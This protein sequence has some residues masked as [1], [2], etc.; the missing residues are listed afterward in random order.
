[1]KMI[2][3][4]ALF[5]SLGTAPDFTLKSLD[6]HDVRL[7]ALRGNV[8]IVSFW[9]TWCGGCKV[10]IPELIDVYQRRHRDG[11][12]I[13]G[14]SMDDAGN[15]VVAR[16][17]KSKNVGYTI[18]RGD[19]AVAK[20]YGGIQFLPQSFVVDR[21]GKLVKTFVGPPDAKELDALIASLLRER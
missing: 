5:A 16:F 6:G 7:S 19:A 13:V 17:A 4:L 21:H 9:A 20:A 18:V 10:E 2:V 1:M 11:L 3:A 8:I 12:E 14:I 15:D